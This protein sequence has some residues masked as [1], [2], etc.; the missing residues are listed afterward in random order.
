M[1][2]ISVYGDDDIK[3]RRRCFEKLAICQA[4]PSHLP[5]SFNVVP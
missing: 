5:G 4:G 2:D 1:A 3:F